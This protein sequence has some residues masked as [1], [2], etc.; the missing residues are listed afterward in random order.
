MPVQSSRA[1]QP[2]RSACRRGETTR[3]GPLRADLLV[4]TRDGAAR[5]RRAASSRPP[6]VQATG[7]EIALGPR[8]AGSE[9]PVPDGGGVRVEGTELVVGTADGE[10]AARADHVAAR[11]RAAWPASGPRAARRR[12]ST[13]TR[14]PPRSRRSVKRRGAAA[15]GGGSQAAAARSRRGE[16]QLWPEHFDVAVDARRR[17]GRPR[18]TSAARP[19]TRHHDEPYLYVGPWQA[20]RAARDVERERLR[21]SRAGLRGAARGSTTSSR[22]RWTSG[23]PRAALA[24]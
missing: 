13:S 17:G 10:R 4:R 2:L 20:A 6:R 22:Q 9:R 12:R 8:P 18:A 7:N 15:L 1:R 19:A 3:P 16:I 24:S 21:R 11:R 14:R 23:A 5:A